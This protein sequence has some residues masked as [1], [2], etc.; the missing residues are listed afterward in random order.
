MNKNSR[1]YLAG[2]TGLVGS[3]VLNVLKK[4]KFKN[5]I[6]VN[7]KKLNLRNYDDVINFFK[8]K[9]IDYLI[10][11]AARAGGI[12]ANSTYQKDFFF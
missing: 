4:N 12:L 2:H 5:I 1:I 10:M 11:A 3:A 7:S 9:K 8:K 6:T